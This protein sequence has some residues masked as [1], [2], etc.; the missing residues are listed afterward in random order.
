MNGNERLIRMLILPRRN[1]VSSLHTR[2]HQSRL[3]SSHAI[4]LQLHFSIFPPSSPSSPASPAPTLICYRISILQPIA[5]SRSSWKSRGALYSE[6][7]VQIRSVRRDQ[8]SSV[9]TNC[10]HV[11]VNIYYSL[12]ACINF[13]CVACIPLCMLFVY[14]TAFIFVHTYMYESASTHIIVHEQSCT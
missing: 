3:S 4:P 2:T 1:Y 5:I 14:E 11:C 9:R 12:C 7:G 10:V 6:Y 13:A 8:S